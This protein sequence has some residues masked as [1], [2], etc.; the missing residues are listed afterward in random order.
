M[1]EHCNKNCFKR[2]RKIPWAFNQNDDGGSKHIGYQD[3][4]AKIVKWMV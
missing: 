2:E 3:Q 4:P 1:N